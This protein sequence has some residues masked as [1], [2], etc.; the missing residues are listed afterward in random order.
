MKDYFGLEALAPFAVQ[1]RQRDFD[2][3]VLAGDGQTSK[4][5][6]GSNSKPDACSP[7]I[8]QAFMIPAVIIVV[9]EGCNLGFEVVGQW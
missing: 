4:H 8:S 1:F 7:Q 3:S 9:D 6:K 5:A 2:A